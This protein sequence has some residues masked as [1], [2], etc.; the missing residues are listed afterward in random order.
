MSS[1]EETKSMKMF[2]TDE[3]IISSNALINRPTIILCKKRENHSFPITI[4]ILI[5][6]QL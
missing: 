2:S 3:T 1:A 5:S 6:Y 4:G